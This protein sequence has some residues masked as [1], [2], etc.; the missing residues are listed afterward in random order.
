MKSV[1]YLEQVRDKFSLKTD[2][3]LA[4]K[5]GV[6]KSAMSHY[7]KGL[8]VMD[9]ETC[10]AVGMALELNEH[11]LLQLLMAAGIDRAEQQGQKSLWTVFSKRMAATAAT[12]LLAAG[13]NLFLTP[14]DANA[15]SMRVPVGN[16]SVQYK[17]CEILAGVAIVTFKRK[18]ANLN[19]SPTIP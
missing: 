13:V 11:E 12:A 9:Q 10:L 2:A 19:L 6:G 5:I 3:A 16:D 17:L 4:M 14:G 8:R 18:S 7:M 15:A 1:K